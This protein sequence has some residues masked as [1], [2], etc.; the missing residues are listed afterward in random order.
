MVK[1]PTRLPS[2]RYDNLDREWEDARQNF[3]RIEGYETKLFQLR[4]EL[5]I[6]DISNHRVLSSKIRL[7]ERHKKKWL[8]IMY[9]LTRL[10]EKRAW[11]HLPSFN[12][13]DCSNCEV[14]KQ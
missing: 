1:L 10:I 8:A 13:Y 7:M 14:Q 9:G 6:L 3:I 5:P 4:N 2:S 11:P 12:I